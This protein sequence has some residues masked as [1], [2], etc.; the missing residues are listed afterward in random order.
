MVRQL[1]SDNAA[2][3]DVKAAVSELKQRKKRLE[4]KVSILH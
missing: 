4:D 3:N 2:A 1:K